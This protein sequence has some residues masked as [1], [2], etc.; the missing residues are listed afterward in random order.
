MI[1]MILYILTSH[2]VRLHK[3]PELNFSRS[4][5]NDGKVASWLHSLVKL[6]YSVIKPIENCFVKAGS[7]SRL[8]CL[9]SLLL[10]RGPF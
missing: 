3:T 7:R 1:Q 4:K 9:S 2:L 6:L 5:D 10:N 8:R